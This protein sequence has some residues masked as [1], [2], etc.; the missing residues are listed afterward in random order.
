MNPSTLCSAEKIA[1]HI[2]KLTKQ[3]QL[4]SYPKEKEDEELL[5]GQ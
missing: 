2:N 5:L 3:I 4:L 1:L